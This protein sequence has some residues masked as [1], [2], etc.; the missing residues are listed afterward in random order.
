[1]AE[2]LKIELPDWRQW[3]SARAKLAAKDTR[4][5]DL[6]LAAAEWGLS[7]ALDINRREDFLSLP[8]PSVEPFAH[9]VDDAILFFRRLAPRGLIADDVGLGKTITAGLVARELLERGRI[10]SLLVVC[11]KSLV[12]QWQEELDSK[13]GIKAAL[14]VGGDFSRLERHQ[15]WITSYH[16]A[17]SRIDAIRARKFDLLI[18]DEAHALRNLYGGQ[19]PPQ[20]AKAFEQ[21]MREDSVR[22]CLMLTATP[23]QNRLWDMF[24][25]LEVLRAPQPNPLG[26]PDN[27]RSQYVADAAA[28]RLRRNAQEEFRRKIAEAVIRTRRSDTKLLFPEREVRTERLR[29]LPDEQRYIEAALEAILQFPKLVQ[30][31]HA[32]TLM[33]SPW[34]AATAFEAEAAKPGISAE[35]RERLLALSRQ[36]RGIV[37]SA[38]IEAVVKLARA[39]VRDKLPGRLIVFT[40]RTE[41]LRHL[42]TALRTAGFGSQI[43]VMQGGQPQAN[44]RAIRDF[45]AE[46]PARPILLSTDTGAVGLNLQAG[47]I[48]VNYDLPW[49]PM[50]IEQRIGRV[51]RLGQKARKVVVHNLVLTGTIEDAVVLRL[52]EKLELF[53]QAIGEMEELLELCGYDEES[54]SLDQVIMDLIRKAAEQKDIEED[55]RRMEESRRDA[56]ARMRDM[57]QATEQALASIRPNDTG[58]RLEGLER[59][60]PRLALPDLVKSCL[61][62]AGADFREEDGHLYVRTPQGMTELVFDREARGATNVDVRAVLPGTRA[63]EAL[64]RPVRDQI[65]HHVLDATTI[66]LDRVRQTLQARLSPAGLILEKMSEARRT[67]RAAV[68]VAVRTAV[69]VASDRY[70]HLLEVDHSREED[71]VEGLLGATDE[72]RGDDGRPLKSCAE[73]AVAPL[74][75]RVAIIEEKVVGAIKAHS[76]VQKFC[77]FYGARFR[78]DL[79]RLLEHARTLGHRPPSISIEQAAEWVAARDPS[80]K[81]ALSSLKLRFVPTLRVDPV[82]VTGIRYDEVEVDALVRNR[83]QREAHKVRLSA[84]PLTGV[85]RSSVPGLE[86]LPEGSEGWACPGGHVTT[87]DHFVRCSDVNCTVGACRDCVG[88]PGIVV[89]LTACTECN[90]AVCDRH[91]V[92]C[93][94]CREP[95]CHAHARSLSDRPMKACYRCAVELEDGRRLLTGDIAVSAVS[96]RRAPGTEM[97]RS[98]LSGRPA[99]PDELVLCEESGRPILPE[100]AE[101]CAITGKR[102]ATDLVER[103]AVSNRPGLRSAMKRSEWSG[104]PCLP[105]EEGVCDETGALL[106]PDE[107]GECTLTQRRV[108]KDLLEQDAETGRLALRRLLRRSDVSGRWTASDHLQS[109]A[110][111]GR[112][113]LAEETRSC[114]VCHRTLL[115]DETA[116]CPETGREACAEHFVTCDASGERVLPDG[117]GQCQVTGRHIRRSLLAQCPETGKIAWRDLFEKCEL[118]SVSVLGEALAASSLSGKRVRRSL[119]AT[120]QA[121]GQLALPE[122][123]AVCAVSGKLVRPDLLVTCP[124]TGARFLT[125][126][127]VTCEESG[128][129]VVPAALGECTASGRR[130]RRS[131]LSPDDMTG[132]HVLSRSLQTCA[133]T[134][135]R[136]LE[137]KLATSSISGKRALPDHMSRCEVTG[138]PALADE[139]AV[140]GV[141]GKAAHPDLLF[142][143]PETGTHLLTAVGE[144]C[145]VSGD[146]VAPRGLATCHATG[147][148]VRRSLLSTDEVTAEVV[149]TSLLRSCGRTGRRT[150]PAN[151]VTSAVSGTQVLSDIVQ[152]C[153]E[154]GAPALPEELVR[155]EATGKRVLPG[156]LGQCEASGRSVLRT[157]LRS[158]EVSGKRVLPDQLTQ[159]RRAGKTVLSSL[160]GASQVS[161]EQDLAELL[162]ACEATGKKAF[163]D[164]LATSQVSG[165]RV[166]RDRIWQC[167]GCS[168][169]ADLSEK[170]RCSICQKFYCDDDCSS[171]VCRPCA[172]LLTRNGCRP[173][174]EAELHALGEARPWIR[175]GFIVESP[176]LLHVHARRGVLSLRRGSRILTFDR[177]RATSILTA[178]RGSATEREITQSVLARVPTPEDKP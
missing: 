92:R 61:R 166:V 119:L 72:L 24:S 71:G 2:Q 36:G 8:L 148:Q 22:Y 109:S 118:T 159:C 76:S 57:R 33:S 94:G 117:L 4:D 131:L 32:R 112:A 110:I 113:G 121:S 167:P 103:S 120:C 170:A 44:L 47:N 49:N 67:A 50:L 20:V 91:S 85:L 11:P 96:G 16:T 154:T 30:I 77:E 165:M 42:E 132:R 139:L 149:L 98:A 106:L 18:L 133:A 104:R 172:Q 105:G 66:G 142:T 89:L 137:S 60:T 81:A 97:K 127:G 46:P 86:E 17:R 82:G 141:T 125:D 29:A 83:N 80:V 87:G 115:S 161:G 134:G 156:L 26:T 51:Q 126:H 136:T 164:E 55:L 122:E 9:Q 114:D 15:F 168:R 111:S 35:W 146:L 177:P 178:L 100:E 41:T 155:C 40:Q 123:L 169:M 70:E 3:L 43:G 13:F 95:I 176:G 25:L 78:E 84:V 160:V 152:R 116:R 12:E 59:L 175:R 158:C 34:A 157:L 65:A 138:R 64:T 28:R 58:D 5:Y 174:I 163:P 62:R 140:C 145:A 124:E 23:I 7:S 45:M 135:V 93:A 53:Q 75:E 74:G 90:A 73:A 101:T 39:S 173:L 143:C 10:E 6:H 130:V 38:K 63:L 102:V 54:R 56:E 147:K 27:F 162:A 69:Q 79:E 144:R 153:E 21:L 129:V 1:M 108:R 31:T 99:F 48:V 107:I 171:G 37:T 52:M 68:R 150:L 151:M 19:A 88:T 128:T 14:A